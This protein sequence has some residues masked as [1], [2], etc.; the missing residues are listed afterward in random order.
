MA[1]KSQSEFGQSTGRLRYE[2]LD[3]RRSIGFTIDKRFTL[4][5]RIDAPEASAGQPISPIETDDT[6]SVAG[7]RQI[8]SHVL[9]V[10]DRARTLLR[11]HGQTALSPS[12]TSWIVGHR[13]IERSLAAEF[14]G[15]PPTQIKT[16]QIGRDDRGWLI[17]YETNTGD[18]LFQGFFKE[19]NP[20]GDG[21]RPSRATASAIARQTEMFS[22][23]LDRPLVV[24]S[25]AGQFPAA[26]GR[27]AI[28]FTGRSHAAVIPA[29]SVT[30]LIDSLASGEYSALDLAMRYAN[31]A[32]LNRVLGRDGLGAVL[33]YAP[34][35]NNE[36][37]ARYAIDTCIQLIR[38]GGVATRTIV[39]LSYRSSAAYKNV[40]AITAFAG[41]RD[42]SALSAAYGRRWDQVKNHA[43]ARLDQSDSLPWIR[44]LDACRWI[45]DDLADRSRRPGYAPHDTVVKIVQRY[46]RTPRVTALKQIWRRQ[47][48][49]RVLQ[50]ALESARLSILRGYLQTVP[51]ELLLKAACSETQFVR[52][53]LSSSFGRR[54]RSLFYEDVSALELR[55]DRKEFDDFESI[56]A[57]R[58]VV[59][60]VARRA[61]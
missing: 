27:N 38:R 6:E 58:S 41:K 49:D 26:W 16:D 31:V 48:S 35:S 56:L 54:G 18:P 45:C 44:Y 8:L 23:F 32:A 10:E 28:S 40:L 60:G 61:Q 34:Q 33:L 7:L 53:R 14:G 17:Q 39:D 36:R 47:V 3:P 22:T 4:V 24:R 5:H 1:A 42:L 57:A 9:P 46:Y 43:S 30:R 21:V 59:F 51:R 13:L 19:H 37:R 12:T 55:I 20:D 2:L 25:R 52:E 50:S 15:E 11:G 29:R